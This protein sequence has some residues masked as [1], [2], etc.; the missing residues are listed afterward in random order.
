ML[1]AKRCAG[2]EGMVMRLNQAKQKM[3]TK[4]PEL[5]KSLRKINL[6]INKV[7]L[8]IVVCFAFV[9]TNL[10][11]TEWGMRKQERE[12]RAQIQKLQKE[13][14][15]LRKQVEMLNSDAYIEKIAREKLGLVKEGEKVYIP[16]EDEKQ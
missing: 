14:Q 4:N 5:K 12:V 16:A 6:P 3:V 15:Q 9:F 1:F 11:Y 10:L 8:V 7:L 13:N 2:M